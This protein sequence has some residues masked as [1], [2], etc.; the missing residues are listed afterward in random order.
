VS[1]YHNLVTTGIPRNGGAVVV[2]A[3]PIQD[4][5]DD[6]TATCGVKLWCL[7]L[8]DSPGDYADGETVSTWD[9]QSSS[10]NDWTAGGTPALDADGGP[11]GKAAIIFQNAGGDKYT[12]PD[13]SALTEGEMIVV[14]AA[15]VDPPLADRYSWSMGTVSDVESARFP[16]Q[17]GK[18]YDDFGSSVEQEVGNPATDLTAWNVYNVRSATNNWS[19]ELNVDD[20]TFS[21]AT[22][23]PAFSAT[24]EFGDSGT[25]QS[26]DGSLALCL[27][28]SSLLTAGERAAVLEAIETYYGLTL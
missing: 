28:C 13:M 6:L 14:L 2:G 22:N 17:T 16:Y 1:R 10:G 15:L 20:L 9:D 3:D 21:T 4:F 24:P 12:L 25:R 27:I 19:A 26:W 11:N 5:I 23:T 7:M 18:V 8:A